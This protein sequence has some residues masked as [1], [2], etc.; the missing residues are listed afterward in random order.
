MTTMGV[1]I[2][3]MSFKKHLILYTDLV[4]QMGFTYILK[5]LKNYAADYYFSPNTLIC[6]YFL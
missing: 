6:P 1:H 3:K 5:K 2:R 4:T